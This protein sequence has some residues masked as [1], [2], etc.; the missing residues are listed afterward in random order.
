MP[1]VMDDMELFKIARQELF[2]A[3]LGDIMDVM[4]HTHQFLPP[5]IKPLR[6][7]MVVVGRAMP[8]LEAD[9][10]GGEGEQR[11][12]PALRQAFG[13]MFA[14]LDDLK[15]QEVYIC[16]GSSPEYALWGE[17]MSTAAMQRGAVGAVV[18]GFHHDTRGILAINF[19]T[20]S[21]GSYAQDQRARGKVVDFRCSITMGAVRIEP[22]DLIFGDLDGVCVIPRAIEQDVIAQAL[23]K[24]R[25]EKTVLKALQEGMM[26]QDAWARFGIM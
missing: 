1:Q 14:A 26:V 16:T 25:G 19:P 6:Q 8:V 21:C 3:V 15:P 2:T 13:L 24:V 17:L 11:R 23:E 18:N 4:G 10:A 9:D 20:F 5:Q 7:D 22:G 12:T